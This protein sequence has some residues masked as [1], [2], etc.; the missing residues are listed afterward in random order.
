[1]RVPP[2][3]SD[4]NVIYPSDRGIMTEDRAAFDSRFHEVTDEE[5][6][7]FQRLKALRDAGWEYSEHLWQHPAVPGE[8]NLASA[9][10]HQ[11]G[12]LNTSPPRSKPY[13]GNTPEPEGAPE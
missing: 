4:D 5:L 8:H 2:R 10:M 9:E 3:P 6:R 11:M 7:L 13:M 1:M 12:F